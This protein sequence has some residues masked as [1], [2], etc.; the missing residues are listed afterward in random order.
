MEKVFITGGSGLLALNWALAIR[1][2][3]SV[4]LGLFDRDIYLSGV[5]T[6]YVK[7]D[8]VPDLNA[9]FKAINP[10]IVIHTA[11]LTSVEA[12]EANPLWAQYVNVELSANVAKVCSDL[13]IKMV[14][15]ST[16]HLFT[17]NDSLVDESTKT[18]P[19]NA[20]ALTKAEAEIRVLEE[21][22]DAL[23]IRTNFYGWGPSYRQSFSDSI[24]NQLRSGSEVNLFKDVFYTP[25]LAKKLANTVHDLI[26][27]QA[28]GIYNVV[29]DE[30]ITKYEYG[31][32]L[33]KAFK[34]D[35]HH[36][37]PISIAD[38]ALVNRPKDMS[39][40]NLKTCNLLG[41]KLGSVDEHLKEL[42][43]QEQLGI[44]KEMQNL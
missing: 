12:C 18:S 3:Y 44:S 4:T 27:M 30:R 32:K 21:N 24:I 5:E 42:Y 23:V 36:V 8:S 35:S 7:L 34:F 40:S 9:T 6:Q 16:D 17:G 26:S 31:L 39:L 29:G 10:Q 38:L 1:E 19:L 11:G 33:A 43:D 28:N 15:I 14:H 20:Y 37:N 2:R 13:G 41:K 25:I 22:P